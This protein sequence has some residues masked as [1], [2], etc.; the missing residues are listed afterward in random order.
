M[1]LHHQRG[2]YEL[3]DISMFLFGQSYIHFNSVT[4]FEKLV[5]STQ[6][7]EDIQPTRDNLEFQLLERMVA[8]AGFYTLNGAP[9]STLT[10]YGTRTRRPKTH[11]II[12]DIQKFGEEVISQEG[13]G[14]KVKVRGKPGFYN[15]APRISAGVFTTGIFRS[16]QFS[17]QD[18]NEFNTILSRGELLDHEGYIAVSTSC[19]KVYVCKSQTTQGISTGGIY[20]GETHFDGNKLLLSSVEGKMQDYSHFLRR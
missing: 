11:E 7:I 18:I 2:S 6:G 1:K 17:F 4:V 16:N 14:I 19:G 15:G 10:H 13:P 3:S 9:L 12:N 8:L 5:D 20:V